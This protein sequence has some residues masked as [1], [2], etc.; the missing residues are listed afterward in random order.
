MTCVHSHSR[1]PHECCREVFEIEARRGLLRIRPTEV[2]VQFVNTVEQEGSIGMED[3]LEPQW[4]IAGRNHPL[5]KEKA[6]GEHCI[7]LA[8]PV[9]Y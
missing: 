2:S 4:V 6:H 3:M 7:L 9:A 5:G 8:V 1:K